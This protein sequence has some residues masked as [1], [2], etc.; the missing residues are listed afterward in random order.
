[1]AS[2]VRFG[3]IADPGYYVAYRPEADICM[4]RSQVLGMVLL[5]AALL[6]LIAQRLGM[7]FTP[8]WIDVVLIGGALFLL[9]L[10]GLVASASRTG[11]QSSDSQN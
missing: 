3:P 9:V 11:Q 1:V 7:A 10:T 8:V 5:F 2:N 4:N 6:M